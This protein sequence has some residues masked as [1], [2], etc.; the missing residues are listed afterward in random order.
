MSS[1]SRL[2]DVASV[3]MDQLAPFHFSTS[4]S[5]TPPAPSPPT[6]KQSVGPTQDTAARDP[7]ELADRSGTVVMLHCFPFQISAKFCWKLPG[8]WTP[9]AAQK[10][11]PV[12]D[13]PSK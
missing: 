6:P 12:H 13:T 2:F 3:T 10:L 9:T 8:Y 1:G 7:L 11:G 4:V 5:E